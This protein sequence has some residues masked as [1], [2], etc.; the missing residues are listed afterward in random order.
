MPNYVL[1]RLLCIERLMSNTLIL[2][3]S[4]QQTDK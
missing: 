1:L 4:G 3:V 2:M